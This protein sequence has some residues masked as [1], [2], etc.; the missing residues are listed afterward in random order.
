M[1]GETSLWL[2]HKATFFDNKTL[3]IEN[4]HKYKKKIQTVTVLIV[5][6][7]DDTSNPMNM[8]VNIAIN[9]LKA[10]FIVLCYFGI[11]TVTSLQTY[12]TMH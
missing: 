1:S 5:K 6:M 11:N 9:S 4:L 10:T 7:S 3:I 2:K 8:C 12:F